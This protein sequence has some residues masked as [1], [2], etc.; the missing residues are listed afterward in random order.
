MYKNTRARK[1]YQ[2]RDQ[3]GGCRVA[4]HA[5]KIIYCPFEAKSSNVG[6]GT[7]VSFALGRGHRKLLQQFGPTLRTRTGAWGAHCVRR[8]PVLRVECTD[9]TSSAAPERG[10]G[11]GRLRGRRACPMQ[12][13]P[14][15]LVRRFLR[16]SAARIILIALLA[17]AVVT[18]AMSPA[19]L[20]TFLAFCGFY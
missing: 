9:R 1:R 18:V 13:L 10:A 19:S 17:T 2:A 5:Q 7:L 15:G 12:E 16:R 14:R 8:A 20:G 3:R 11:P 6:K 4:G